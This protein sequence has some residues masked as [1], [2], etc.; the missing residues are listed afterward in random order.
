MGRLT[1]MF[2][3][4]VGAGAAL[5]TA[6]APGPAPAEDGHVLVGRPGPEVVV[7]GFD[8]TEWRLSG[9]LRHGGRPVVLNLWASW[10]LPCRQ[11]MPELS[12]FAADHPQVMVVGVAVRDTEAAARA[13]AKEVRPAYLVGLDATGRVHEQYP[14]IGMPTTFVLDHTGVVRHVVR[15]VVTAERLASLVE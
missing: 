1:V 9:H 13:F 14:T 8:G 5:V 6:L 2:L 12:A 15:G 11:E 3:L 7:A 10:C 4:V